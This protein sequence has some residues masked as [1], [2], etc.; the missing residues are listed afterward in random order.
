M[1]IGM[2]AS[3]ILRQTFQLGGCSI[4]SSCLFSETTGFCIGFEVQFS[5]FQSALF[6]SRFGCHCH[7][8]L[9]SGLLKLGQGPLHCCLYADAHVF[10]THR[11]KQHL[12]TVSGKVPSVNESKYPFMCRG[13][14]HAGAENIGNHT[15][16]FFSDDEEGRDNVRRR[17]RW[18]I[19]SNT[20][21]TNIFALFF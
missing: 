11:K 13:L 16:Q 5:V 10:L 4:L 18:E 7:S 2:R 14:W 8:W 6:S 1:Q 3:A 12:L 19:T 20:S 21:I 17:R 9:I 15:I